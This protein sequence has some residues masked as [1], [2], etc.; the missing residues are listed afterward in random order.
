LAG[1]ISR[2]ARHSSFSMTFLAGIVPATI[3]Q[4]MQSDIGSL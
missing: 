2:N 3:P 1:K 4:K